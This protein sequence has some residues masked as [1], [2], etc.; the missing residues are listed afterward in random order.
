MLSRRLRRTL[1]IARSGGPASSTAA[2]VVIKQRILN[3]RYLCTVVTATASYASAENASPARSISPSDANPALAPPVGAGQ[4]EVSGISKDW[5][6]APGQRGHDFHRHPTETKGHVVVG[7]LR[8]EF[9][10]L[11]S[12]SQKPVRWPFLRSCQRRQRYDEAE[13][14]HPRSSHQPRPPG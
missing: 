6:A 3:V 8:P 1:T 14:A 9:T 2:N 12:L 13:G 11:P 7:A 10:G 5:T 4:V